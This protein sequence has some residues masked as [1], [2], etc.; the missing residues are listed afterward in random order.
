MLN[1]LRGRFIVSHIL[2]L[3]IVI[4]LLGIATIYLTEEKILI[5]SLLAELKGNA[6]ALSRIA[7]PD[8]EIWQDPAYAQQLL[9]Q[10]SFRADGRLMLF[11]SDGTLLASSDPADA[12]RIGSRV[13]QPG[14]DATRQGQ[15]TAQLRYSQGPGDDSVDALAPVVGPDGELLGFVRLSFHYDSFTEQVYQ[16]R[17]LLTGILVA[18]S[19][20]GTGLGTTLAIKGW[21]TCPASDTC[22]ICSGEWGTQ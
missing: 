16:F 22:C 20:L 12:N 17:Y 7:A 2:P 10:G 14:F 19:L 5:P 4:P 6:L 18:A 9:A 13:D 3:L 11:E 21:H 8:K 1:T 15:V